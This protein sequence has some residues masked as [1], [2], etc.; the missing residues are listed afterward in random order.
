M[1][2][3]AWMLT[4]I[5]VGTCG[6]CAAWPAFTA[7]GGRLSIAKDTA[8]QQ[9]SVQATPRYVV[10]RYWHNESVNGIGGSIDVID[11][12]AADSAGVFVQFPL[13]MYAVVFTPVLGAQH[14]APDPRVLVIAENCE[15]AD[16]YSIRDDL[17]WCCGAPEQALDL[18]AKLQPFGAKTTTTS[19]RARDRDWDLRRILVKTN[20]L[21]WSLSW[22]QDIADQDRLMVY[23]VLERKAAEM[24]KTLHDDAELERV[25]KELQDQVAKFSAK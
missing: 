7:P 16:A 2:R 8:G 4:I 20:D 17:H 23:R 22:G 5:L 10:L 1:I 11:A 15:P 19:P 13:R 12:F 18:F 6:G 14:L 25:H 24:C 21:N 9:S 3:I